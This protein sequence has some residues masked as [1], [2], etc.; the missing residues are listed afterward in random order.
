MFSPKVSN[1]NST[2]SFCHVLLQS[3]IGL[4][5][6]QF[7]FYIFFLSCSAAEFIK[8]SIIKI[9]PRQFGETLSDEQVQAIGWGIKVSYLKRNPVTVARQVNYIFKQ[10]WGKIILSGMNPIHQVLN[11]DDCREYQGRGTKHFH[12]PLH[13]EGALKLGEHEDRKVNVNLLIIT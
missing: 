10:V 11:F 5:S 6:K 1:L 3:L 4:T 13:V 2:S 7:G 9:S 12:A 8:T